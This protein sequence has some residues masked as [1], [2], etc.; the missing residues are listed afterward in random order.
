MARTDK[1][2]AETELDDAYEVVIHQGYGLDMKFS[3][4]NRGTDRKVTTEEDKD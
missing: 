2:N 1:P 4:R 3:W